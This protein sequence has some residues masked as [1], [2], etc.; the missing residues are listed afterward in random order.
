MDRM[1]RIKANAN[2]GILYSIRFILSKIS[3]YFKIQEIPESL[4]RMERMNRMKCKCGTPKIGSAFILF[5]LSIL[6]KF[7][8]ISE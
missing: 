3:P 1:E 7:P 6:S 8:R 5:I 2:S 4:D